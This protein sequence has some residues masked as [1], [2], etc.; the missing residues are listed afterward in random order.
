MNGFAILKCNILEFMPEFS[1]LPQRY[2]T[3]HTWHFDTRSNIVD[4][5]STAVAGVGGLQLT[6]T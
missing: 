3:T 1:Y 6:G 5:M 4:G 2:S